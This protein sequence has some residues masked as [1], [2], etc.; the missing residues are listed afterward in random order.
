MVSWNKI[1]EQ[2]EAQTEELKAL[3]FKFSRLIDLLEKLADIEEAN[4]DKLKEIS[5][6]LTYLKNS[7]DNFSYS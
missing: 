1:Y 6:K 4:S 7:V 5:D 3:N 2:I